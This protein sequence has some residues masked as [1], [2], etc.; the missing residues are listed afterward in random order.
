VLSGRGVGGFAGMPVQRYGVIG[1]S[2][3]LKASKGQRREGGDK[4]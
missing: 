4:I 3:R 2:R 1:S